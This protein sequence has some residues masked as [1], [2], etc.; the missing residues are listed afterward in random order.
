[1]EEKVPKPKNWLESLN[2]AIEGIIYAFKTQRNMKYHFSI[3]VGVLL[4]SLFLNLPAIEF[5]LFAITV[6]ML[7]FA[8]MINSAIEE[9]VNLLEQKYNIIAKNAKDIAA[10]AVLITS[11]AVVIMGYVIL[12]KY[13]LHPLSLGL[14]RA[15]EY[16]GHLAVVSFL[17]VIIG[18]VA[19]KAHFGKGEP[20]HGGMPSG[21]SAVA[22]SLWTSITFLTRD[23]LVVILAFLMATM[24]SHSRLI[25][26]THTKAEIIWG[27]VLGIGI[28]S[29]IFYLFSLPVK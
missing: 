1:M 2:Y 28:T 29:F 24:V 9:T 21:H 18:V 23:P 13:L 14:R 6:I 3:A 22:F 12:S 4:I 10:G 11:V 7:L 17:I 20:L 5:V 16:T 26:E 25:G 8:E 19:T 15:Q 27:A